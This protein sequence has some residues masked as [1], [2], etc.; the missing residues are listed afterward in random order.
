M[1][2]HPGLQQAQNSAKDNFLHGDFKDTM[3]SAVVESMKNHASMSRQVLNKPEGREGLTS[4]LLDLVCEG[5]R[6]KGDDSES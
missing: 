4:I 5:L 1:M 6:K 3:I 2:E